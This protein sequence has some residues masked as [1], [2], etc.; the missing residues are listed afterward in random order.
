MRVIAFIAVSLA[1][2]V[3]SA[4]A[5]GNVKYKWWGKTYELQSD[6]AIVKL[7]GIFKEDD[8]YIAWGKAYN[9]SQGYFL[10]YK[11]SYS[12][13][14]VWKKAYRMGR[15]S[16]LFDVLPARNGYYLM[17]K[18]GDVVVGYKPWIVR[19]SATG[20]ILWQRVYGDA[21][22]TT[23][24]E[25]KDSL[26]ATD[27]IILV[28]KYGNEI[29]IAKMS[30][31]GEIIWQKKFEWKSTVFTADIEKFEDG[32]ILMLASRYDFTI[33]YFRKDF[34]TV[35]AKEYEFSRSLPQSLPLSLEIVGKSMM[36]C[37][38]DKI[39]KINSNG[40]VISTIKFTDMVLQGVC[41]DSNGLILTGDYKNGSQIISLDGSLK[42]R[43]SKY[44]VSSQNTHICFGD[45]RGN[46]ICPAHTGYI[47]CGSYYP[48][49]STMFGIILK[50]DDG[51]NIAFNENAS[52]D[53]IS[54]TPE[55]SEV[56]TI[57][58]N[59]VEINV[60]TS[61][62]S[63][64]YTNTDIRAENL[65]IKEIIISEPVIAENVYSFDYFLSYIVIAVTVIVA[66]FVIILAVVLAKRKR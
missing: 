54:E 3:V 41:A 48:V 28:C 42:I 39:I 15:A 29:I 47:V 58:I 8:G 17:G 59:T 25:I 12:G 36:V 14:T 21:L 30:F 52:I 11:I 56:P 62:L 22:D 61:S 37:Y 7:N 20:D 6:Q 45:Y 2:L 35:W 53:V 32:Y 23:S 24:F 49:N 55:I 9:D 4:P 64:V 31:E 66:V 5:M 46:G 10:L 33:I 43:W 13:E 44:F 18:N 50:L 26:A 16:G 19:I 34:S 65:D 60:G 27:G 1:F 57:T 63:W 40:E 51:G 38:D